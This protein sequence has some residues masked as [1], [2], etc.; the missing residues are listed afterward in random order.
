M[1]VE[2]AKRIIVEESQRGYLH[3]RQ[4][5]EDDRRVAEALALC[6]RTSC[7]PPTRHAPL[8]EAVEARLSGEKVWTC[9]EGG[10]HNGQA[11]G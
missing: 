1:T 3:L 6:W 4:R 2:A 5:I 7:R 8:V 10:E 11:Q 9:W